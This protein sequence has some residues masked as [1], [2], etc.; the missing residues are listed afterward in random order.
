MTDGAT[1]KQPKGPVGLALLIITVGIGWLLSAQGIGSGI[2]WIWTLG[3]GMVGVTTFVVSGGLD[4]LS[5][6]LG[7]FF[8][9]ASLLS[10][11]RQ[12]GQLAFDIEVPILVILI[13]ILL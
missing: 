12:T 11:L 5:V 4:K 3:L 8:L 7:P 1:Q 2:N 13:G 10:I 9:V 6:V